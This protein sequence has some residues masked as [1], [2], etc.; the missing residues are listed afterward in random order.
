MLV[1]PFFQFQRCSQIAVKDYFTLR[2]LAVRQAWQ[3]VACI[4]PS[5]LSEL[6]TEG[7]APTNYS[8]HSQRGGET[9]GRNPT[10]KGTS[11]SNEPEGFLSKKP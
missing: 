6:L 1:S 11:N 4:Q 7:Q 10:T 9:T 5:E 2:L 8:L 3:S